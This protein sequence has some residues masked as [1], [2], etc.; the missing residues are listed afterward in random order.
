MKMSDKNFQQALWLIG[1]A[2][3]LFIVIVIIDLN[4]SAFL[5]SC[6]LGDFEQAFYRRFIDVYLSLPTNSFL[7]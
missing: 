4:L 3:I 6:I 2:G 1:L 5:V 7:F